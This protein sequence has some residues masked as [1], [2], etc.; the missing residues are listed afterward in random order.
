MVQEGSPKGTPLVIFVPAGVLNKVFR[1]LMEVHL[2]DLCWTEASLK[3]ASLGKMG[4]V[5]GGLEQL[6]Q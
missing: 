5:R 1:Y 4:G 2:M 6:W 3:L